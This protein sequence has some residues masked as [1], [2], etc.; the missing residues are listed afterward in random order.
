MGQNL[1]GAVGVSPR[2]HSILPFVNFVSRTRYVL[3]SPPVVQVVVEKEGRLYLVHVSITDVDS[4]QAVME[5][6]RATREKVLHQIFVLKLLH[7]TFWG[8]RITIATL[9]TFR[10]IEFSGYQAP[11][12][13]NVRDREPCV[14]LER[15][16]LTDNTEPF[17]ALYPELLKGN[18]AHKC[19]LVE[20]ELKK[21][22]ILICAFVGIVVAIAAGMLVGFFSRNI[23][24]GLGTSAGIIGAIAFLVPLSTWV[25]ERTEIE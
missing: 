11:L 19:V 15:P 9:C 24:F 12:E 22:N 7:D 18:D 4:V 17:I 25:T 10:H 8:Q 21:H 20:R 13:V 16:D 2:N 14:D 1:S 3:T 23:G 6:V 5:K